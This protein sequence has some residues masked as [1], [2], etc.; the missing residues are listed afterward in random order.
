MNVSDKFIE[1]NNREDLELDG[2]WQDI[3]GMDWIEM[4]F[5]LQSVDAV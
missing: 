4:P 2:E 1:E 5:E 3:E